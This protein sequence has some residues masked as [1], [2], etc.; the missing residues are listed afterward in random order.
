MPTTPPAPGLEASESAV[1]TVRHAATELASARGE[2]AGSLHL[3]AALLRAGDVASEL[4][5]ERRVK[6]E[7]VLASTREGAPDEDSLDALCERARGLARSQR[8]KTATD[9][10]LLMALL[11]ARRCAAHRA[12][13]Q[14]KVDLP[15]LRAVCVNAG[16]GLVA[17]RD[18]PVNV[19]SLTRPK[20]AGP[21]SVPLIQPRAKPRAS[22]PSPPLRLP[23]HGNATERP[24]VA[25]DPRKH[26]LLRSIGKNLTEL[27]LA[28]ELEPVIARPTEMERV[29]DVLAKQRG[30]AACLVG[31]SGVGKTSIV[32][33]LARE[34]GRDAAF[35]RSARIVV[36]IPVSSLLKGAAV[37]GALAT[38]LA[39]LAEEVATSRG[40]VIVFFDDIHQLFAAD[41]GDEAAMELKRSLSSGTFSCIAATTPERHAHWL[42]S[43]DASERCFSRI[44]IGEPS[45]EE[46]GEI[47]TLASR[48]LEARHQ[49]SYSAE[50]LAACITW[51]K[52]YLTGA[53]LPEKAI[54]LL[55]LTGA[56][57][58]RRGEGAV[59][60]LRLAEAVSEL[61]KLPVERLLETDGERLLGLERAVAER[62]VGHETQ[63]HEIARIV[64][65][66]AAGLSGK[67]PIGTFLLLGP[68]G[69][70]KTETAKAVA[71]VLF[72]SER[73]L[74]RIDL[75]EYSEGHSVARLI[76]APPGYVG[77]EAGGQLTEA[78]R[79]RPYQVILLDE[80]EK[81]HP[82]VHAAFLPLFDEGRLTDG[83]GRTVDFTNTVIFL[84]SNLGARE[85][86]PSNEGRLGFARRETIAFDAEERVRAAAKKAFSPEFFNRLDET[87]VFAALRL[88]EVEA[89]ARRLL[90]Q[91]ADRV[92]DQR[93][94]ELCIET[95]V[96]QMLVERG[97]FD[98]TLG[99]RP[100]RRAIARWVEA[101]LAEAL[102]RGDFVEGSR[103][104]MAVDG[105]MLAMRVEAAS[106][107]E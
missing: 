41:S 72:G 19:N 25:L 62:V 15:R 18:G 54:S 105:G 13:V 98:A 26:K 58:S 2:A 89:I 11:N 32:H 48:K 86:V 46:S 5:R 6:V 44:D 82:D 33:A 27:A 47:L 65:R 37:R 83:Q 96:V 97:G 102:L 55:D 93:Q 67:R 38:R 94:I 39:Q 52:R 88:D 34:L 79:Q 104:R 51:C 78:V 77:F 68:T 12:L 50:V 87:L 29:L 76:G 81:A 73:A 99:A 92:F 10:H 24:K 21:V 64:R 60:A 20:Y 106:A 4:L 66:N 59:S 61:A 22:E 71:D 101:P 69:V 74:T 43:S 23:A 103:V 16:L 57:C 80:V 107:A 1:E 28:D 56:R 85:A 100:M 63:I 45:L 7:D 35:G 8:T 84:T 36:E 91:L 9:V 3:L 42:A 17:R 31:P 75:S 14:A 30:N 49:V 70:G 95:S 40:N 90:Q 53:A